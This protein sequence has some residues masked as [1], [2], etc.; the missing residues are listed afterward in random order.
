M[1]HYSPLRNLLCR[2][3]LSQR[4]FGNLALNLELESQGMPFGLAAMK[5]VL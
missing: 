4:I 2:I 1:A 3:H 5:Y